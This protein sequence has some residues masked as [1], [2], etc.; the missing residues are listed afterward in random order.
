MCVLTLCAENG[1]R[2]PWINTIIWFP[3]DW[4]K[5]NFKLAQPRPKASAAIECMTAVASSSTI[6][7]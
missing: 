4:Y 7:Q 1:D 3:Y 5:P 2:L 6:Q